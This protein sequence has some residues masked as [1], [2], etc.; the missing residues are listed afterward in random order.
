MPVINQGK[1]VTVCMSK[2]NCFTFQSGPR[3]YGCKILHCPCDT[4]DCWLFE[5]QDGTQFSLNP[6]SKDFIGL[7]I[8]TNTG[9]GE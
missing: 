1:I 9:V 2:N 3:I 4:G 8:E 7:E 5:L 6:M